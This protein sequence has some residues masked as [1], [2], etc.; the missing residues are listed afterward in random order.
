MRE[1]LL[2][3]DTVRSNVATIRRAPVRVWSRLRAAGPWL[4]EPWWLKPPARTAAAA[5]VVAG[6]YYLSAL[7]GLSIK[8]ESS[9]ISPIYQTLD[10]FRVDLLVIAEYGIA[11]EKTA[12][13]D[14]H[15]FTASIALN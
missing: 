1:R 8:F 9:L 6:A 2:H 10:I 7:V 13:D 11:L 3:L 12:H 4:G 15:C 14:S 5:L